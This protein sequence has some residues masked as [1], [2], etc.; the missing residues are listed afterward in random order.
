M[1]Y[2]IAYAILHLRKANFPF[3]RKQE[4]NAHEKFLLAALLLALMCG[5][6]TGEE[7]MRKT[8]ILEITAAD[9]YVLTGKRICPK[10]RYRSWWCLSTA[11]APTHTT[12]PGQLD[13]QTVFNYFDLFTEQLT[14]R[15]TAFFRWSTLR[16]LARRRSARFIRKLTRPPTK[17]M[18][19]KTALPTWNA[20][21]APCRR[22]R[23]CK[24]ARWCCWAGARAR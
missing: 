20:W 18:C 15:G 17:L 23:G 4:G 19:P 21:C 9:G 13:E 7:Q 16:L 10:A 2:C 1:T 24:T 5:A 3:L 12:T 14:S 8:E 22:T 11:P 6:A